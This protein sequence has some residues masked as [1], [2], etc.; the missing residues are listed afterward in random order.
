MEIQKLIN[1]CHLIFEAQLSRE[2][3]FNK[4]VNELA[5]ET[6]CEHAF[7]GVVNNDINGEKLNMLAITNNSWTPAL[8][9][10]HN[11]NQL[12][13]GSAEIRNKNN[14]IYEAITKKSSYL[15]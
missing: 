15:Q 5:R 2:K 10:W 6:K 8:L 3:Y 9:E 1:K 4:V 7:M 14:I 13:E 11:N 12:R